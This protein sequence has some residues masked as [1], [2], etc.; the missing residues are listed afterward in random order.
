MYSRLSYVEADATTILCRQERR[1][2]HSGLPNAGE[3]TPNIFCNNIVQLLIKGFSNSFCL[4]IGISSRGGA[5]IKA[6][7]A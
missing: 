2:G 1:T 5:N 6:H 3:T 4:D 7:E